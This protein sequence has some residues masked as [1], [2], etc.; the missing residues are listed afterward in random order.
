LTKPGGVRSGGVSGL[1]ASAGFDVCGHL[2][3]SMSAGICGLRCLRAS[4]ICGHWL[5]LVRGGASLWPQVAQVLAMLF[6]VVK[7]ERTER[8]GDIAVVGIER[9]GNQ[10]GQLQRVGLR[11]ARVASYRLAGRERAE[12][13]PEERDIEMMPG[14]ANR[15]IVQLNRGQRVKVT[16]VGHGQHTTGA[17]GER[18]TGC[19]VT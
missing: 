19:A 3:A 15:E 12:Q 1:R 11:V 5:V 10:R 18:L 14:T 4:G 6:Q 9:V 2:R 17:N 8:V 13:F 7:V 16:K